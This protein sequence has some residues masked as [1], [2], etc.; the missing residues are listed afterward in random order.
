MKIRLAK[1][2]ISI[3]CLLLLQSSAFAQ[4][5]EPYGLQGTTVTALAYYGGALYAG[6]DG[7]GLFVRNPF[8]SISSKFWN[9]FGLKGVHIRT[10]YPHEIGP[11]GW[12]IT[13]GTEP[14]KSTGDSVLT[15]CWSI[16]DPQWVVSDSNL[17]RSKIKIIHAFD[18]FPDPRI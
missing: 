1:I 9:E 4:K 14:D 17:D 16:Y 2:A 11:I 6:T 5:L 3:F 7:E 18:G 8:D 10:V 12:G 13:I 15:Y